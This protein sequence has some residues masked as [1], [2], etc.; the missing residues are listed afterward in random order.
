MSFKNG[1]SMGSSLKYV[2][3]RIASYHARGLAIDIGGQFGLNNRGKTHF[4]LAARNLGGSLG[5]TDERAP[6]PTTIA[7]GASHSFLRDML[8]TSEFR[9]N[10]A[11]KTPH[12]VIGTE[13]TAIGPLSLRIGHL[14]NLSNSIGT[15]RDKK[16]LSIYGLVG[17]LGL[18]FSALTLDYAF[19][20]FGQLGDVHRVSIVSR[21]GATVAT[22]KPEFVRESPAPR[23][24]ISIGQ[25][26]SLTPLRTTLITYT[27]K[28]GDTLQTISKHFYGR[29]TLWRQILFHNPT[30]TNAT[31]LIPGQKL[32]IPKSGN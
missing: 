10:L 23:T 4:G 16:F 22:A 27:V 32:F 31:Q 20:P 24:I 8:T 9:Y 2:E 1:F 11:D 15:D 18:T 30:I 7:V 25:T 21:F 3:S 5:Y 29:E 6:L 19:T 28:E 26:D 14:S 13:Y 17:G 12:F